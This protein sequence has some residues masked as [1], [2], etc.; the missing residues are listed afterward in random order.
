MPSV[1]YFFFFNDTATTE[2]Y[3]LSL[4]DALPI[5]ADVHLAAFAQA[6]LAAQER[7]RTAS[8]EELAARLPSRVAGAHEEFQARL[9]AA[10][11]CQLPDGL[12][13]AEGV[14]QTIGIIRAH[15]PL[16]GRPR[17][18][19]PEAMLHLEPLQKA[20]KARRAS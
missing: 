4:H 10:R 1:R 5:S 7:M 11:A 2:I 17:V 13:S 9:E 12:V 8:A 16:P 20:I 14:P 15:T 3:T 19:R 6:L 18:P